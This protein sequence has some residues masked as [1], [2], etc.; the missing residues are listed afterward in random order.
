MFPN[1]LPPE[2]QQIADLIAQQVPK[3][4]DLFRY[5]LVLAMLADE[6]ARVIG[7]REENGQEW[8][9]VR[10]IGGYVFELPRPALSEQEEAELM[11]VMR[12][13]RARK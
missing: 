8:L 1:N 12:A 7:T 5:A 10:T 3:V 9:A 2:F 11:E 6:K 4:R 13:S